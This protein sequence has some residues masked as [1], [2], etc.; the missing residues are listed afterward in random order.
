ME[1]WIPCETDRSLQTLKTFPIQSE[2]RRSVSNTGRRDEAEAE[3]AEA[4]ADVEADED[5]EQHRA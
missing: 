1:G 2:N 3:E 4:E 5:E